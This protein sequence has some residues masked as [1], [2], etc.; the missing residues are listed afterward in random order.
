MIQTVFKLYI[1]MNSTNVSLK[2]KNN[3]ETTMKIATFH[4]PGKN[5]ALAPTLESSLKLVSGSVNL[6]YS[7]S[8]LFEYTL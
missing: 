1:K 6:L 7:I 5:S 3:I 2:Q 8:W 4:C